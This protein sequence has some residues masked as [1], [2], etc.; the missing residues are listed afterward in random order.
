MLQAFLICLMLF[1]TS[2]FANVEATKHKHSV[3]VQF[4][5]N[6]VSGDSSSFGFQIYPPDLSYSYKLF[7]GNRYAITTSSFY[8]Q[9]GVQTGD[10]DFDYRVGQ[11]V[12]VGYEF[13]DTLVYGTLGLGFMNMKGSNNRTS[14]VY[15]FGVAKDITDAVAFMTELNF[16]HIYSRQIVNFSVGAIYSFDL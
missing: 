11:R 13:T 8:D 14:P 6:G 15:G 16:Q 2:V 12:D 5:L 3:S 9:I 4:G 1:C 7:D 10:L